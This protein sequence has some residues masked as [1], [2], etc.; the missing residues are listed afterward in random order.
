VKE[1]LEE[2]AIPGWRNAAEIFKERARE[3]ASFYS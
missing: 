3:M 2:T 1:K